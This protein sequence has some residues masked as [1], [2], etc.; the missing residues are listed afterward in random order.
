M[1]A[2][3]GRADDRITRRANGVAASQKG[4]IQRVATRRPAYSGDEFTYYLTMERR[5]K[6]PLSC[7]N[8]LQKDGVA[9]EGWTWKADKA[10]IGAAAFG[11]G[12]THELYGRV[13]LSFASS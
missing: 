9:T 4:Q 3:I 1:Q 8:Q 6:T 13:A 11:K 10:V 12:K 5:G 2:A 7:R